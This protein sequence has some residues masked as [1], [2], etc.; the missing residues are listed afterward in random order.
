MLVRAMVLAMKETSA[1]LPAQ[2][3]GCQS[4]VHPIASHH[5]LHLH[6]LVLI[7]VDRGHAVM[8]VVAV[9]H[10]VMVESLGA[11]LEYHL[12]VVWGVI[13]FRQLGT[14]THRAHWCSL[15]KRSGAGK[16][17]HNTTIQGRARV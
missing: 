17:R 5:R 11:H 14:H 12:G 16:L 15:R 2:R 8:S 4:C 7:S 9:V 1:G 13:V 3:A 10:G 6:V